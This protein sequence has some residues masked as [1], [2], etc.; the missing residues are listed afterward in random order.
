M[1]TAPFVCAHS[2]SSARKPG[3]GHDEA[4]LALDRLDQQR[5]D[6]GPADLL[7]DQVD[8]PR[9]GLRAGPAVVERIGHRRPVDLAGERPEPVLVR[10]VLRGQRHREVG[11]AVIG[12]V[13]HHDRLPPGRLPRD[14]YRVLN[15]LGARVEQRRPLVEQ[16]GGQRVELL[17]HGDV[18]LVRRDHETRVGEQLGLSPHRLDHARRRVADARDRDAGGEVDPLATVDVGERAAAGMVDVRRDGR[19][20]APSDGRGPALVQI[21]GRTHGRQP[22]SGHDSELVGAGQDSM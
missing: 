12:V 20:H 2:D 10:Q 1:N 9:G 5:G 14:L 13:E 4:A 15:R 8:G 22:S 11:A 17:A 6:V 21:L 16:A 3:R 7:L 18:R 19:A